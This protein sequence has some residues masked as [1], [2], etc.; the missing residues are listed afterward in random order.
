[1]AFPFGDVFSR[2]DRMMSSIMPN[3][4]GRMDFP[5]QMLDAM[6]VNTPALMPPMPP[7]FPSLQLSPFT[8][9]SVSS[10]SSSVVSMTTDEYGRRQIYQE[11]RSQ[12]CGPDGVRETKATIHDS[13]T[14]RQEMSVGHHIREKAHVVKRSRNAYNGSEEQ[15]EDFINLAEEECEDFERQYRRTIG[16]GSSRRHGVVITEL[17]SVEETPRLALPAPPSTNDSSVEIVEVTDEQSED[18]PETAEINPQVSSDEPIIEPEP[19]PASS[20][21]RD[22][23]GRSGK[24][25]V[26]KTSSH[27]DKRNKPYKKKRN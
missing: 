21:H 13:R 17:P 22:R 12:R 2:V 6:R 18:A 24:I 7:S 15:E 20:H 26:E 9:M 27:K 8:G 25:R 5:F 1:M 10:F 4:F 19:L 3:P 16:S 11:T 14:G 23:H